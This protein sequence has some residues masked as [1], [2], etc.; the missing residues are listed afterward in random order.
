MLTKVLKL[1]CI[2]NI[3]K[4]KMIKIKMLHK[5]IENIIFGSLSFLD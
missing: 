2:E 5:K 3:Q 4:D 1:Y